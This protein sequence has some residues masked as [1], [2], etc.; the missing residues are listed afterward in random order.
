MNENLRNHVNIL[1]A[2]APKNQKADEIKEELLTNLND[3]YNDLLANGYDSTAAFH[4]ALSG[5]GDIDEL[6]KE[7]GG[8]VQPPP[9]VP[10][11]GSIPIGSLL[12]ETVVRTLI[13]L[14]IA[15][16][17]LILTG[18]VRGPGIAN[19]IGLVIAGV[20]IVYAVTPFVQGKFSRR[21]GKTAVIPM[22]GCGPPGGNVGDSRQSRWTTFH[23]SSAEYRTSRPAVD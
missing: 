21:T 11:I 2:A 12:L 10:K 19:L 13:L 4:V 9:G 7:C 17:V 8:P 23:S 3:K 5:I 6:L 22:V 18:W 1:F 14:G 20:L 16:G 15:F